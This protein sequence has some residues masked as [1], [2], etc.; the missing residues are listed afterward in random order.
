[1]LKELLLSATGY[2]RK[3]LRITK[4]LISGE[5]RRVLERLALKY[6]RTVSPRLR[7]E[8]MRVL[9]EDWDYLVVLDAC[10]Y[11]DFRMLNTLEGKLE[12]RVSLGSTTSEWAAENFTDYYEDVVYVSAN[13]RISNQEMAGFI[14][15]N[16][17]YAVEN[18]W[19]YAWDADLDTVHPKAV[20]EAAF[21]AKAKYPNKRLIIHYIQPHGPW[22]SER[23]RVSG[24]EMVDDGKRWSVDI[25]AWD[26]VRSGQ[27]DVK[28]LRQAAR[29]NLR[30]ALKEV[31]RLVQNSAGKI[32]I[33]ADHGE[34]FGEHFLFAHP[35][36]VRVKEL[37]EVPWLIMDVQNTA[38][39][40]AFDE[41]YGGGDDTKIDEEIIKE[42]L[43]A[44][45]YWD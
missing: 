30:L 14:G 41:E 7:T 12:K 31:E 40:V 28:V 11:D 29:E 10:R 24:L 3:I 38:D 19:A 6:Y 23:M 27:L 44:L 9:E 39:I 22:I 4:L 42:R 33:T 18:V 34:C 5:R 32:I 1:M 25:R 45:G 8:G 20:T 17:F 21:R 43:R 13:P 15:S 37:I 26:M 36:G 2:M 16:H 35:G